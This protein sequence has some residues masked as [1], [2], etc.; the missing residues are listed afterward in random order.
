MELGL[1]VRMITFLEHTLWATEIL[2]K[3]I[4]LTK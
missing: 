1:R 4:T 3:L 2:E